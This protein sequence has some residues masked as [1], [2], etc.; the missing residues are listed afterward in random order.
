MPTFL[1]ALFF[2]AHGLV[3]PLLAYV[4]ARDDESN[5]GGLWT[6]SWLLGEGPAVKRVQWIAAFIVAGLFIIAALS[7]M[8]WILPQAW[9]ATLLLIAVATSMLVLI[10]FWFAEF[11][12]GVLINVALLVLLLVLNWNPVGVA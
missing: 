1:I 8:G 10:V 3:H 4:P 9:W 12:P 11:W 6:R 5:I 2:V 7:L